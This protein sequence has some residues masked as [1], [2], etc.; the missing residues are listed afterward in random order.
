V[1]SWNAKVIRAV[2]W[3]QI[4][5]GSENFISFYRPAL[6]ELLFA[7]H[8]PLWANYIIEAVSSASEASHHITALIATLL[9][10]A[11]THVNPMRLK[12]HQTLFVGPFAWIEFNY[13][14]RLSDYAPW[15]VSF[16]E[17]PPRRELVS[18]QPAVMWKPRLNHIWWKFER[19]LY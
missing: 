14:S 2:D 10:P 17:E 8:S 7:L 13:H 19:A 5:P 12:N 11:A 1:Q 16:G 3:P 15:D 18:I 4:I 9:L 6:V